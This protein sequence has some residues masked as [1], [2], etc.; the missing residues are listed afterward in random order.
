MISVVLRTGIGAAPTGGSLV[1]TCG[2]IK[3]VDIVLGQELPVEFAGSADVVKTKVIELKVSRR[4]FCCIEVSG[5]DTP[6]G[7]A[8]E[9]YWLAMLIVVFTAAT[10][11]LLTNASAMVMTSP[12]SV[13]AAM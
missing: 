10:R 5:E 13:K 8:R 12:V 3:P 7:P 2:T 1:S 4:M 9:T 6:E 11:A